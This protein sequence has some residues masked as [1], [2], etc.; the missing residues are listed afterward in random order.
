M[1]IGFMLSAITACAALVGT[2]IVI[3]NTRNESRQVQA[4]KAEVPPKLAS[5]GRLSL[6]LLQSLT[7]HGAQHELFEQDM[8]EQQQKS[9]ALLAEMARWQE[10]AV[11]WNRLLATRTP[12]EWGEWA[13]RIAAAD[14]AT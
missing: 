14:G 3:W 4:F 10:Q 5:N 9:L 12:Q 1:D 2:V 8:R 6:E 7:A 13:R 11:E